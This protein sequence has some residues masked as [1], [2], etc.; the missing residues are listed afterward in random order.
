MIIIIVN[1]K[2]F[3]IIKDSYN[4]VYYI[5]IYIFINVYVTIKYIHTFIYI[6]Y[7]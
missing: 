5:Y 6:I 7:V 2:I 3:I 4:N 1:I